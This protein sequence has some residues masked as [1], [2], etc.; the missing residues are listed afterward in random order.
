[1]KTIGR[2]LIFFIILIMGVAG[3]AFYWTFYKPLPDYEITL[4]LDGLQEPVTIQWDDF[5][6]PHIYAA[7][8]PD[9]YYA[10]GYVHAQDRLWQMTVS[11]ILAEGRFAEFFGNEEE[12]IQL[13][14]YQRTLGFWRTAKQLEKEVLNEQERTLLTAYSNGINTYIDENRNK[15]PVEFALTGIEPIRWEPTRTL[16]IARMVGWDMNTSWWTEVTYSYL[17]SILPPEQ[18]EELR[19]RFPEDAPTTLNDDES[20]RL[21]TATMPMLRQEMDRR[22]LL[23][24]QGSQVGSNAWVVDGSKTETGYPML[25]GDPHMGL[26]MP[27]I[28]YEVHLNVQGKNV[29]GATTPGVPFVVVGQN[30]HSAW[31]ITS[32]MADDTDFFLEQ[33]DPADRGQ[34]VADSLNDTTAVFE[35]FL[36]TR[37]IIKVKN[38]DEIVHEV[39][40]TRHG[41]IISDIYPSPELTNDQVISMRWT[42][43]EN[44]NEMRALYGIN[45]SKNFQQFKEALPHFGVPGMN[46]VYGDVS[47]NIAMYSRALIPIRSGD[48]LTLRNGWDPSQ[49]WTGFIP[50]EEMPSLINPEKGWIA[51]A[52]NK[53]TTDVYPYYIATF[54]EPP[55]RIRRIETL[56][57]S[58]SVFTSDD[59][60]RF[61]TDSYSSFAASV[62][63]VVLDI[64]NSQ[65]V[66]D[67]SQAASYLENWNYEYTPTETAATIF[68][69]FF[70]KFTENTLKDEFGEEAYAHF[71]QH[72][73]VPVRTLSQLLNTESP[74]F[75]DVTTDAVESRS[76]IVVQS[77]RDALLFLSDSLGNEPFE[78]RWE[79]VHTVTL[80]PPIFKEAARAPD[81][82][83]GLKMMVNNV[84]SKGPY[85]AVAHGMSI[86]NGQYNWKEPF[87]MVLGASIRRIADLS[88]MSKTYSILPTGQSGN[89]FSVHFGDQTEDWVNGSYKWLV[90]DSSL[91]SRNT[92]LMR[93]EPPKNQ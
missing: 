5:G 69:A 46:F 84:L 82:G 10:L 93:L 43:Y 55:S 4:S 56:L 12:L 47:G 28:W 68:D 40:Y 2:L 80:S 50:F 85:P 52:N 8:E 61:Q 38:G 34:Y 58:D 6:I 65:A 71:L 91:F 31:S 90:Q 59:F 32:I 72:E 49:D 21:T 35:P 92:R 33:V 78:W 9:V 30:D 3:L 88:D 1:M 14:K 77:M 24:Q 89:P 70:L 19:L 73:I 15:L 11:Q 42:G 7:N 36:K 76:D 66:Y 64:L 18:F 13:D 75:D 74:L 22:K 20:G 26:F 45:W 87:E 67:F 44:T 53:I 29:S 39:R 86:N 81:A 23:N 41:P 54:W 25:A 60:Q 27:G 51:N 16:A 57:T 62:T 48:P 37:E 79:N 83:A 17:K 63:P